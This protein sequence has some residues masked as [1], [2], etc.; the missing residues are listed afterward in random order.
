VI[1]QA[2]RRKAQALPEFAIVMPL[3]LLMLFALI[4]FSR[5]LFTYVS[6]NNGT[7]ELARVASITRPWVFNSNVNTTN[8][9]NA[10][11]N[12]TIFGGPPNGARNF[13]FSPGSGTITCSNMTS[14]GCGVAVTVNYAT[15]TMSF[16]PI[17]G[18]GASGSASRAISGTSVPTVPSLGV[19]ADG[20]Y[21]GVMLITEGSA[22]SGDVNG[23]I[24]ICPLPMTTS[25]ALTNLGMARGGGGLI[26]VD[27][28]YSF[29]F[30][31][32]FENRLTN[33][34]VVSFMRP[35]TAL[36]TTTRTTGE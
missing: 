25:C 11:N 31:P 4:D 22:A 35:L 24:Q 15:S 23:A 29:H 14:S 16:A 8:T 13:S 21:A 19:T 10:F 7:R 2:R 33:V 36:T 27:A 6:M 32:L 18:G 30:N 3:L 9:V 28:A 1:Q 12:L 34:V 26:E 5:L 17:S 20:D